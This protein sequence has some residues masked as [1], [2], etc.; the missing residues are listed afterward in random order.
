MPTS[1]STLLRTWLSGVSK[2]DYRW[3]ALDRLCERTHH[4][5]RMM[6]A[7]ADLIDVVHHGAPVV[8]SVRRRSARRRRRAAIAL[9]RV[10]SGSTPPDD[11]RLQAALARSLA[12]ALPRRLSRPTVVDEALT[13]SECATLIVE[14]RAEGSSVRGWGSLHRK[15][16][17]QDMPIDRLP[18]GST[19]RAKLTAQLVPEFKRFGARFG[20]PESLDFISLFVVRYTA[21]TEEE[22][23]QRGLAGH[24]DESFLSFVLQLSADEAFDGGGTSFE[25]GGCS[26]PLV[27]RPG[28]GSAVLFLGRVWHE[29]LPR[30][31]LYNELAGVLTFSWPPLSLLS[32]VWR[33]LPLPL[34]PF[35]S[36][37]SEQWLSVFCPTEVRQH[38]S[39]RG[40]LT[41]AAS[42]DHFVV[43][44]LA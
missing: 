29:A 12:L 21:S 11:A 32:P 10:C 28:M 6:S 20:P 27:M 13:P 3:R 14:C 43:R 34:S 40:L 36:S 2:P 18:C 15:Y 44:P 39:P 25:I 8:D 5:D 42:L 41:A 26:S 16:S 30:S 4:A 7:L 33:L 19:V 17:T 38:L 31:E 23:G 1:S 35:V 24:I 9:L 22:G 37:P